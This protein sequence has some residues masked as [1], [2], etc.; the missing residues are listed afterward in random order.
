MAK[1]GFEKAIEKQR[2]AQEKEN[3]RL[4]MMNT[5]SNI[6]NGQP[7]I[8]GIRIMDD[9]SEEILQI[10]LSMFDKNEN[11]FVSGKETDFP[12]KYSP[13]LRMELEKLK[14]YGSISNCFVNIF[15]AWDVTLTTQG[16]NYFDNKE[17]ALKKDEEDRKSGINIKN[18][19]AQGSNVIFGNVLNST[20]SIDESIHKIEQEIDIK[21][22]EDKEELN[23]LLD[24]VKEYLENL[25][26]SRYLTKNKGLFNRLSGHLSKHGWFYAEIVALIGAEVIK[27]FQ[28]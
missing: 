14:S 27:L 1:S 16:I 3:K 24:E 21:G 19:N 23:A 17:L 15:G 2:K 22:N 12:K 26:E 20:L 4:E 5:V 25:E 6:V 18:F 9:S 8:G 11:N 7:I 28:G 13:S 10:I